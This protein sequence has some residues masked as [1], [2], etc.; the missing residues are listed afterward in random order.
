LALG[1]YPQQ[2][3]ALIQARPEPAAIGNPQNTCITSRIH[4]IG[5]TSH[6][7]GDHNRLWRIILACIACCCMHGS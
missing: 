7:R 4:I 2:R 6:G 5:D 3:Y 1:K